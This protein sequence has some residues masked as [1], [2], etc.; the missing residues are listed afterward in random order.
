MIN[1]KFLEV[2]NVIISSI[3]RILPNS[4]RIMKWNRYSSKYLPSNFQ[5]NKL[6]SLKMW[7]SKLVGLWD[8][9]ID[10]P[11]LKYIGLSFSRNLATTPIFTGIPKLKVL[12][13]Q[14]C[15]NLVEIHPSVADLKWLTHLILNGCK[16][17]KS[18]P[19]EIEMDSLIYLYLQGC[20]KLKK[21]PEF[22]GQMKKIST[23]D[24]KGTPVEKLPSSI[25]RLVGLTFLNV[26]NCENLLGLPSEIC[27]LKSLEWLFSR[28]TFS[29][30]S[31][32][33]WGLQRKAF[34]LGSVHGLWSLKFLDL[35][36][37]GLCEG[38]I[39][40]DI[41]CLSSLEEL[42]LSRNNFVSLPP[43]IGC[44]PKLKS[45]KVNGCQRLQQLPH[46]RFGFVDNEGFCEIYMNTD[47]CTSL[48]MLPKLSI[49]EGRRYVKL[50]CVNCFGLVENE[51]CDESIIL[52]MLWIA[53]DWRFLQVPRWNIP[54]FQIVTPGSRI[55]EWFNN[56][57]VGYSLIVELPSCTTSIWIAFCDVFEEGAPVDHPNPPQYLSTNSQIECRPR[58]G[59]CVRSNPITKGHLVSPHLWL[60][61]VETLTKN[62]SAAKA[63][64]FPN[65]F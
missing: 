46:L 3:P 11:N 27:N 33:W 31:R 36:D 43:S 20:S 17:V 48:T 12:N 41:G 5:L 60:M 45:L 7:H 53:M 25:G 32:F 57:S 51:G 14:W 19:K 8:E 56:Q 10:L 40:V 26:G 38:D 42:D 50:R 47:D 23:P 16:S 55:P 6:V 62:L 44:L 2:D 1:L 63:M 9:R 13:L 35:N 37:C 29:D 24:L 65:G 61:Q 64:L 52:G 4:L 21:I 34:V 59:A 49:K 54:A 58:E 28:N 22:S 30:K 39:P 18:L 15:E